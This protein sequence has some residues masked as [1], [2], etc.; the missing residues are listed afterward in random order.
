MLSL[1]SHVEFGEVK[2]GGHSREGIVTS[3]QLECI[4]E[5]LGEKVSQG[6]A[7]GGEELESHA[8]AEEFIK[9]TIGNS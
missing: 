4:G 7:P 8:E 9:R 3:K 1:E 5:E 2:K 6:T